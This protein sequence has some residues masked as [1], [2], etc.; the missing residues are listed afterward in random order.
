MRD[1]WLQAELA[2]VVGQPLS[3]LGRVLQAVG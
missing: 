1:K 3:A 2:E